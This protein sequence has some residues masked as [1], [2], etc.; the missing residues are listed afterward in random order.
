MTY[1]DAPTSGGFMGAAAGT[2]TFM[3]GAKSKD[4]FESLKPLLS[5]MGI[6]FFNCGKSGAGQMAKLCNNMALGCQ[7]LNLGKSFGIDVSALA[8]IMKVSTSRC[9]S[10]DTNTPVP[11]VLPG[12]P[13][14]NNYEGGYRTAL[15]VKDLTL[16]IESAQKLGVNVNLAHNSRYFYEKIV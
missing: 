3:I 13:A 1:V 7:A 14:S 5:C 6:N 11:G 15:T 12:S 9:W 2:L 10:I 8:N 16:A 4:Q